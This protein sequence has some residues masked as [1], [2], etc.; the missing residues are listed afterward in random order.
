MVAPMTERAPDR[1]PST[2]AVHAGES[3]DP[4]TGAVEPPVVLATT[5]AFD[6]A[7]DAEAQFAGDADGYIYSRWR[8]PSV[9]VFE[10]KLAAMEGAEAGVGTASGMAAIHGVLAAN[11]VQGDH[12]VAPRGCYAET[13][14]LLRE[15]FPRFGVETTFVDA[16]DPANI[17][18]AMRPETR[19]VWVET[20][21][22]PTLALTDL[23]AVVDVARDRDALIVVDGTFATPHHQ[24]PLAAGVDLVVHSAT[25]AIG[26]HG[27]VVGGVVAGSA[28]RCAAVRDLAVRKAG[29]TMAPLSAWLLTR[30]V[31]TLPLRAERAAATA[32]ELARRL[33][34]DSR[35]AWVRYPGL[36]SHPQHDLACH[37][38]RHGFG[39]L[40][41]F[42]VA[43][44]LDAGRRLHDGVAL[45]TRAV[46]L[47]DTRTLLTH[48]ASTTHVSMPPGDR[49]AAG[50]TDGLLRLSVGL[51]GVDDLWADLD[52]SLALGRG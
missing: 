7:A 40:V 43:G 29:G 42:E 15:T 51:E 12:V 9:E 16:T 20:P 2:V 8:N 21:A 49:R 38:M 4:T 26:G 37:Q 32:L 39:A 35:V 22:N 48:P 25:K 34:R 31:K 13:A 28:A 23:A 24:Q 27:D 1:D 10:R 47:G 33:E 14:R 19:I 17:A 50:I 6:D 18:A 30:G 44:G 36:P 41:A 5:Y 11:L 52:R 3:P 45:I 46:S